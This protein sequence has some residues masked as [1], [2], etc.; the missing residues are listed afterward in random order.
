MENEEIELAEQHVSLAEDIILRESKK[1]GKSEKELKEFK[2]AEFALEKAESE[3]AD[4]ED[5]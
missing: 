1:S 5:N 3:I 2:E 4:L